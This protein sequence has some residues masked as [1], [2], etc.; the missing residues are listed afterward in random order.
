M[1]ILTSNLMIK[2]LVGLAVVVG[3]VAVNQQSSNMRACSRV[4]FDPNHSA[5]FECDAGFSVANLKNPYHIPVYTTVTTTIR[6]EGWLA[7]IG[8]SETLKTIR[9]NLGAPVVLGPGAFMAVANGEGLVYVNCPKRYL[10]TVVW[11]VPVTH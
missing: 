11:N 10:L 2:I 1:K 9:K 4:S 8:D 3:V 5:V 6:S 7:Q